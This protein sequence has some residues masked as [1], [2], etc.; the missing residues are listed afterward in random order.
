MNLKS[1]RLTIHKFRVGLSHRLYYSGNLRQK[2]IF[3]NVSGEQMRIRVQ[4][5]VLFQTREHFTQL[6]IGE[7]LTFD[8][9]VSSVIGKMDRVESVHI[10]AQHL[11]HTKRIQWA[12]AKFTGTRKTKMATTNLQWESG[13]FVA[14]IT[15]NDMTLNGKYASIDIVIQSIRM[16]VTI[17][18][19]SIHRAAAAAD[20]S[21]KMKQRNVASDLLR[22]QALTEYWSRSHH[23]TEHDSE[24]KCTRSRRRRSRGR[25]RKIICL[26]HNTYECARQWAT[27]LIVYHY[28]CIDEIVMYLCVS[29]HECTLVSTWPSLHVN[30]SSTVRLDLRWCWHFFFVVELW[31]K[32]SETLAFYQHSVALHTMCSNTLINIAIASNEQWFSRTE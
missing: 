7:H 27:C 5:L 14:D 6:L 29:V 3:A 4:Q 8:M 32:R 16:D 17:C 18:V 20:W 15:V 28:H 30:A 22:L 19:D 31:Y 11:K 24:F 12:W 23:H 2:R 1:P 21:T 13:T 10:E 9:V 26:A 25:T